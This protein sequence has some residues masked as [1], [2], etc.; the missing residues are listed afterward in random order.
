MGISLLAAKKNLKN[1]P[2]K[3]KEIKLDNQSSIM[4]IIEENLVNTSS[5][6]SSKRDIFSSP[7]MRRRKPDEDKFRGRSHAKKSSAIQNIDQANEKN[8]VAIH[9]Q[10]LANL[11]KLITK[12]KEDDCK[13]SKSETTRLPKSQ[14]SSPA[15]SKKGIFQ[16]LF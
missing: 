11:E 15:P 12:L 16:K 2:E 13:P 8:G 1:T 3:E 9:S 4:A 10:A 14:P 7:L 5:N 6:K